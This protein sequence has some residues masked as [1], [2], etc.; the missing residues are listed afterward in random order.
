MGAYSLLQRRVGQIKAEEMILSG[1]IYTAEEMHALGLVDEVVDEGQGE[2]AVREYIA[3]NMKRHSTLHAIQ[4]VR[5]RVGGMTLQELLDVTDRWVEE[6]LRLDDGNLK[7][8][9][10]LRSAQLRR[11]ASAASAVATPLET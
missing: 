1:R 7:R 9:E 5:R 2:V 4:D 10:K 6:G 8:M 11:M 3:R